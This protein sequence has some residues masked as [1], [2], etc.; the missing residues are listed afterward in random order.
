MRRIAVVVALILMAACG[1][2]GDV[3]EVAPRVVNASAITLP[4]PV[5]AVPAFLVRA[6]RLSDGQIKKLARAVGVA[7][8]APVATFSSK[9]T[10]RRGRT[11]L[12][13]AAV[14]P[15]TFRS[16]APPATRVAEFV[17]SSLLAGDAVV[18]QRAAK[19]LG[20]GRTAD[21][22][23]SGV[24]AVRVG[25]FADNGTPNIADVVVDAR[26]LGVGNG[27][28]RTAVIGVKSGAALQQVARRIERVAPKARLARLL[29]QA[30]V[31][32]TEEALTTG[33]PSPIAAGLHPLLAEA[34]GRLV[35]AAGGRV[36][37]VSGYRSYAHQ[38]Q[39]W[40]SALRRYRDPEVADNWVAHPGN[41][42]HEHGLAVDLGGDLRLA[43]KLINELQLPLW[44][45]MNWEPWHFELVGSRG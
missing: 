14:D 35:A 2:K 40:I 7:V 44:R 9:A 4:D 39:L 16:V 30:F 11:R 37:V 28:V 27:T 15:V 33:T 12:R 19:K 32:A 3:Y 29:P 24:G 8:V 18:T 13:V 36:W 20:L 25:A 42:M 21:I 34:V 45:P 1:G 5:P 38:Y 41:S 10:G 17:W 26:R 43:A 31:V 23:L 6:A 22:E